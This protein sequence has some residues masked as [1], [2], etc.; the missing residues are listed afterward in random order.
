YLRTLSRK[1]SHELRTPIAVVQSSLD[2]LAT[3]PLDEQARVYLQRAQ[4]GT[5]RLSHT[6]T[7]MSEATRVEEAIRSAELEPVSL[8]VLLRD[9]GEAYAGVHGA[10]RIRV[11]VTNDGKPVPVVPELIVQMLDKLVDNAASFCPPDGEIIL[12]YEDTDEGALMEVIN[13]GP[14]LPAHM[15]QQ[16]FDNM[17]SL[18]EKSD[19]VH[20][21][22]GLH[23]VRLI[24]EYHRGQVSAHNRE[25]R[26]GVLFRIVLPKD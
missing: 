14:L 3:H 10:G 5:Q 18:R 13:D 7:A 17:V 20:L 15:Q 25:D 19:A 11:E 24:V 23:I 6:L 16:L 8:G 2:N 4:E 12:R 22:L 21:G 1:L 26:R 9:I